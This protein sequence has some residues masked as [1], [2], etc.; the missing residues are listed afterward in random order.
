MGGDCGFL[1]CK[2]RQPPQTFVCCAIFVMSDSKGEKIEH[3]I[4]VVGC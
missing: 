3:E 4:V 1:E 2:S